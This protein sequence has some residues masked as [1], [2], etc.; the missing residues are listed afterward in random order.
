VFDIGN[1]CATKS[2]KRGGG[3]LGVAISTNIAYAR[4]IPFEDN[5]INKT[6]NILMVH[7][8]PYACEDIGL[9]C[10][11]LCF[12]DTLICVASLCARNGRQMSHFM[13][14][15][16]GMLPTSKYIIIVQR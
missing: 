12:M 9:T 16:R 5:A 3:E 4:S 8:M 15:A 11:S 6:C 10:L 1:T 14:P 2:Y 7:P 13:Y